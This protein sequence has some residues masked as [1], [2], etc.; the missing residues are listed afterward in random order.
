MCNLFIIIACGTCEKYWNFNIYFSHY[1]NL[2]PLYT[3]MSPSWER[4]NSLGLRIKT[5]TYLLT[6][7]HTRKYNEYVNLLMIILSQFMCLSNHHCIHIGYR[8]CLVVISQCNSKP[9]MSKWSP[10]KLQH[11]LLSL[12]KAGFTFT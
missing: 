1:A 4:M 9:I 12:M 6:Y 7:I 3:E 8:K 5:D 10:V 11:R 2:C